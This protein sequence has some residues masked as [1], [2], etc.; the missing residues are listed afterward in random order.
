MTVGG[1]TDTTLDQRSE[2][3]NDGAGENIVNPRAFTPTSYPL[4]HATVFG[5]I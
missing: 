4:I 2:M 5:V 1:S 3:V